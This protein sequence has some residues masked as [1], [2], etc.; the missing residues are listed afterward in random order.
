MATEIQEA[1][2]RH[3]PTSIYAT[4]KL[5]KKQVYRFTSNHISESG[6]RGQ[7]KQT[8]KK[9]DD[10]VK[11]IAQFSQQ[12]TTMSIKDF[13]DPVLAETMRGIVVSNILSF[14]CNIHT[15]DMIFSNVVQLFI[16]HIRMEG[17]MTKT[18]T[19]IFERCLWQPSSDASSS[20]KVQL[21]TP[22]FM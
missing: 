11:R 22:R 7:D 14:I 6:K 3:D 8:K 13:S 5:D 9:K 15:H 17:L 19:R 12:L 1:H 21:S 20:R 2:R 10:V 16:T 4:K 18:Q